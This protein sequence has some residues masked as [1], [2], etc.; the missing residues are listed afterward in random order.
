MKKIL[1]TGFK[2]YNKF[3]VNISEEVLKKI[4]ETK[5]LKKIIFPVVFKKE[6]IIQNL[7]K[8]K[9]DFI[10]SFGQCSRGKL[11]RMER[12]NKKIRKNK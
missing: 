10:L 5:S 4:K 6:L 3:K 12:R 2:P 1:L 8:L 11:L 9:P 7:R